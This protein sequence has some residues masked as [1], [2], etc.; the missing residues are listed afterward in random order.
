MEQL[1]LFEETETQPIVEFPADEA[2]RQ[3][4][5]ALMTEI[6]LQRLR[7]KKEDKNVE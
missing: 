6:L 7:M 2:T 4:I 5:V 1:T 3:R